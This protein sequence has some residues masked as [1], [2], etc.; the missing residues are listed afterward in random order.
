M[1]VIHKINYFSQMY[2]LES[3]LYEP[4]QADFW[5]AW[6]DPAPWSGW[7]IFS[8]EGCKRTTENFL[9]HPNTKPCI[10]KKSWFTLALI[11]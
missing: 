1:E 10:L 4:Q 6:E 7:L 11:S 8:V 3:S 5:A 9:I 2:Q